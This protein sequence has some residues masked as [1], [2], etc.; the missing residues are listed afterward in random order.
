M[1]LLSL[2]LFFSFSLFL[3]LFLPTKTLLQYQQEVQSYQ[4]EP[5]RFTPEEIQEKAEM[6]TTYGSGFF[7]AVVGT[8]PLLVLYHEALVKHLRSTYTISQA[9][10]SSTLSLDLLFFFFLLSFFFF[11]FSFFFFFSTTQQHR[12]TKFF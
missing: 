2:F 5:E 12:H 1:E 9:Y 4:V 11:L 6:F 8:F 10:V 7:D 3:S